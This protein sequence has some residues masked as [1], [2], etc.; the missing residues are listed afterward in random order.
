MKKGENRD[1]LDA[2]R[3]AESVLVGL[4]EEFD[5]M[6]KFRQ[7]QDYKHGAELLKNADRGDL[8]PTWQSVFRGETGDAVEESLRVLAE[9]LGG[10]NYFVVS[11]ST[12]AAIAKIPWR[13]GRLVMPCGSDLRIQCGDSCANRLCAADEAERDGIRERLRIWRDSA[14]VEETVPALGTCPLCGEPREF[15]NIYGAR[16]DEGGYLPDW[17]NY[18]KWLQGTLNK[19]LVV[20]ELGV[21]MRFPSVIRF[22]FEK[23]AYFNQKAKFYR[24]NGSL[25]QLTAELAEKGVGIAKNA[26]DWLQNL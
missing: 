25:Y 22:P 20:L 26:I 23:I 6:T 3:E 18:T 13:E 15:N 7:D 24:V 12:N 17:Q 10:Q 19:N 8:I 11:V 16:Y 14:W 1:I 2:I 21:G 9:L 4:G 5:G